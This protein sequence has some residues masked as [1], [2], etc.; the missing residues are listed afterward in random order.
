MVT[1]ELDHQP[2]EALWAPELRELARS[3]DLVICN[4]ECC[5]SSRG[6]PTPLIEGKPFFFRGPPTAVDALKAMNIREPEP[7][8]STAAAGA[9]TAPRMPARPD[10]RAR[11]TGARSTHR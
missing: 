7:S 1:L 2:P 8:R 11:H 9:L 4:L 10:R 6:R 3:L 5:I